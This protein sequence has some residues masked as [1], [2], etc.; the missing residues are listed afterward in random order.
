MQEI[1]MCNNSY[2]IINYR[3]LRLFINL[4]ELKQNTL[5]LVYFKKVPQR[6]TKY[7]AY[8]FLLSLKASCLGLHTFI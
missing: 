8:I 1:K 2:I 7:V 3:A 5:R 6:I 4:S